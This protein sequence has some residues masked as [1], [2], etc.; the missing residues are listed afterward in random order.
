MI[1]APLI[2]FLH[3]DYL[4]DVPGKDPRASGIANP[5]LKSLSR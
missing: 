4:L 3:R 1:G 2:V 5:V